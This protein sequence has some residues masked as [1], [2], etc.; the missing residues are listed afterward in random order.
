MINSAK[1][2]LE[3]AGYR[4]V[5]G[6]MEIT[7]QAR[8]RFKGATAMTDAE[9]IGAIDAA[10]IAPEL[11][12]I[13]SGEKG[14]YCGSGE[15]LIRG[16]RDSLA[17]QYPGAKLFNILAADT[18]LRYNNDLREATVLVPRPDYDLTQMA[19]TKADSDAEVYIGGSDKRA[20]Q[21]PQSCGQPWKTGDGMRCCRCA[22]RD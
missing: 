15:A 17:Q 8:L 13:Q 4:V 16:E 1:E 14:I 20:M 11:S 19:A 22:R 21:A 12:W 5:R 10:T 3:E 2:R 7:S 6:V 9:R 18:A